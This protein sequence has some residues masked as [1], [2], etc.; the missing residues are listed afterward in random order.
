[1]AYITISDIKSEIRERLLIE[2]T[3]EKASSRGGVL[4]ET[5][6][7]MIIAKV[8][9]ETN[10]ILRSAK[11]KIPIEQDTGEPA[12]A[13]DDSVKILKDINLDCV[14]YRLFKNSNTEIPKTYAGA[15]ADMDMIRTGETQLNGLVKL[16]GTL[17]MATNCTASTKKFNTTILS[18]M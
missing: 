3:D 10:N 15:Y 11:Y 1:M 5:Y 12:A 17:G 16:T 2:L 14:L 4:N 13:Y 18:Q 7:N 8:E 9:A 6:L